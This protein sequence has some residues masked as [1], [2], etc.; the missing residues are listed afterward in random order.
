MPYDINRLGLRPRELQVLRY[1]LW[2]RS[3]I[4]GGRFLVSEG[5]RRSAERLIARK[6]LT[7]AK[8]EFSP[9]VDWLVVRV[10]RRNI[11]AMKREIARARS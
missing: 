2:S 9:P 10:L 11:V 7:K 5:Q 8:A 3:N 4:K 6:F 1:A